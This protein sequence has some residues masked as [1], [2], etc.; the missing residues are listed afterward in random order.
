MNRE[1]SEQEIRKLLSQNRTSRPT[2]NTINSSLEHDDKSRTPMSTNNS[3]F[4]G[5][6]GQKGSYKIMNAGVGKFFGFEDIHFSRYHTTC[7]RCISNR[8]Q[9]IKLRAKEF[10]QFLNS[11]DDINEEFTAMCQDRDVLTFKKIKD[12]R[13]ALKHNQKPSFIL[14]QTEEMA[15]TRDGSIESEGSVEKPQRNARS[16]VCRYSK[17]STL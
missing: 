13:I 7:V 1:S 15:K 6:R 4:Q 12:C 16:N 9:L 10:Q 2:L 17:M 5:E 3:L 11:Y 8:G 14:S